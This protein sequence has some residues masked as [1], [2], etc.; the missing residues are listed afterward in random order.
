MLSTMPAAPRDSSRIDNAP[1]LTGGWLPDA[2]VRDLPFWHRGELVFPRCAHCGWY[3]H[4]P[5]PRCPQCHGGDL[6][7]T[8]VA[9][10]GRIH[11]FTVNHHPWERTVLTPYVIVVVELY[12][13]AGLRL[14][15][16]LVGATEAQLGIGRPVRARHVAVEDLLVPV[17]E[18]DPAAAGVDP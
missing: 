1:S 18:L 17:F 15:A 7:M 9:P 16:N 3:L 13:Q 6:E 4:P 8:A 14:T 5:L 12:A 10:T 2:P 11:T